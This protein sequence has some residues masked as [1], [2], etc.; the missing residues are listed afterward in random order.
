MLDRTAHDPLALAIGIP[1]GA[2]EEIDASIKCRFQTRKRILIP[3]V[4]AIR[5]P[6]SQR[7]GTDLQS[8]PPNKS[9]LHLRQILGYLLLSHGSSSSE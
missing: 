5:Q 6:P 7:N 2:V 8:A 3:N 4:A 9:I 1:L